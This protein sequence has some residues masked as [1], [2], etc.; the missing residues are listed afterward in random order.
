MS[1][2][3]G[4]NETGVYKPLSIDSD[5]AGYL[6]GDQGPGEESKPST[7]VQRSVGKS[8]SE[9]ELHEGIRVESAVAGPQS[10]SPP[11]DTPPG[12]GAGLPLPRAETHRSSSDS[13]V[14]A[15]S[16]AR[17]M[18]DPTT[19]RPRDVVPRMTNT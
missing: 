2:G 14:G 11:M 5:T 10:P 8:N 9:T 16:R 19:T 17:G 18:I 15:R 3:Q 1:G 13:Q 12:P 6:G 4:A 7:D